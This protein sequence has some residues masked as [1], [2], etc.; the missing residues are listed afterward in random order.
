MDPLNPIIPGPSAIPRAAPRLERLERITR[1][2]DRPR[3]DAQERK[4][5]QA[6]VEPERD[7]AHGE[8]DDGHRHID[9]RV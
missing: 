9:I 5:R 1:E 3:R 6:P 7:P 4:R 2:N 8:D